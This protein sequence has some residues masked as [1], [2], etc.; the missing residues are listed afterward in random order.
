MEALFVALVFVAGYEVAALPIEE[1][2]QDAVR[3]VSGVCTAC[4][5]ERGGES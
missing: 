3:G 4:G 1:I 2:V 5:G